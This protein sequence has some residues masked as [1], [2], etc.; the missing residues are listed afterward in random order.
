MIVPFRKILEAKP[1]RPVYMMHRYFA[2]RPYNLF[3]ELIKHYSAEG[4]LILDPF[5][6]GGVT[7]VEGLL[8][9]RKVI[10]VDLNPLA[11]YVTRMEISPVDVQ[12]FRESWKTLENEVREVMDFLYGTDCPNCKGDSFF[13]PSRAWVEW[14]EWEDGEIKR[15]KYRCPQGHSG[16]KA[17]T[18]GD[19]ER[20]EEIEANF[21]RYV[22]EWGLWYPKYPIPPGDKTT[23]M[24]N[25]GYHFFHQL[26]TK[27]NLL[28]LA[29]LHKHI[30]EVADPSIK[31]F[32]LF[33]LSASLKWA[34]KQSHLRGDIVEGWAM[35][36]YWIY[37][38][39]LEINVW[40]TFANRCR[41]I[42]RGKV[43]VKNL[44]GYVRFA[45]SFKDFQKDA[46]VMLLAQSADE[47]PLPDNSVDC[48][49]T[50][51]P[52][53]SNVN[54][55]E[56]S[57]YWLVW[58]EG[59]LDGRLPGVMDKEKEIIINKT[60]GKSLEDYEALLYSVFSECYRVL[61]ADRPLV[62]T[63]NSKDLRII[64]AFL[65]AVT[66]A[67]FELVKDGVMYQS[68]VR[69]YTTTFHAKEVGAFTGD[70]VFTFRRA[71]YP[72]EER[73]ELAEAQ[74]MKLVEE[75]LENSLTEVQA[76]KRIYLELIPLIAYSAAAMGPE[77]YSTVQAVERRIRAHKFASLHFTEARKIAR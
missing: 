50:D 17:P 42:E 55:G 43:D 7:V 60:Q 12:A 54:Y 52:Y 77:L 44:K 76:R 49:I 30:K 35:H 8:L 27:R 6:G 15:I 57:D 3:Q 9:K 16:E 67:G 62:V 26:F 71:D 2:R 66:R 46:T 38:K 33:A 21:E 14:S 10:G 29:I 22:R 24:I 40:R 39:W 70:F 13:G 72:L 59:W 56:L 61:K 65:R 4:D 1:H 36:A 11:I 25:K 28:A 5:C 20:I 41:A 73:T 48:I 23:S 45:E 37:P 31:E 58:L 32:L 68:P 51:P 74:V 75:T 18:K 53:G 63:F 69:L 19:L 34:S 47:L 64:S